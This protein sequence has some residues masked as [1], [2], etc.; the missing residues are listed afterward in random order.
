MK[1]Q[2]LPEI[3]LIIAAVA[4]AVVSFITLP[5]RV[6]MQITSADAEPTTFDKLPAIILPFALTAVGAYLSLRSKRNSAARIK[7]LTISVVGLIAFILML[8]INLRK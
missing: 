4:L 3:L 1:K 5:D 2:A 7:R 8:I 6:V